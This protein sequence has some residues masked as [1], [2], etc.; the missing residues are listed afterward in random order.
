MDGW[1]DA[2]AGAQRPMTVSSGDNG[3]KGG[4]VIDDDLA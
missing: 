2:N 4:K 1:I 3:R